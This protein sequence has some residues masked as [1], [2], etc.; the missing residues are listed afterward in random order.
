[1]GNISAHFIRFFENKVDFHQTFEQMS[2][3]S[4]STSR[5]LYFNSPRYAL[6]FWF[7]NEKIFAFIYIE[8]PPHHRNNLRTNFKMNFLVKTVCLSKQTFLGTWLKLSAFYVA[9]HM[10]GVSFDHNLRTVMT[11]FVVV[12]HGAVKFA[13]WDQS[14]VEF[15]IIFFYIIQIKGDVSTLITP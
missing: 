5:I 11:F 6:G 9:G 15:C 13:F 4:T 8:V 3:L 2:K 7:H 14:A 1:M 10:L 12:N